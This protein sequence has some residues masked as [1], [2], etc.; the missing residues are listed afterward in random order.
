MD[1]HKLSTG[2]TLLNLA[3]AD[4]AMYGFLSG[5]YYFLVGDSAAGKTFLSVTCLAEAVVN[6]RFR[7]YRL[8]YDNIEDGCL[9][10]LDRLFSKAVAD[11]IE[12]PAKDDDGAP[13]YSST[14]EEFYYNVDDAVEEGSSFIYVL[15]SMDA[16]TSEPSEEKF[17]EHK[18]AS[19]KGKQV[20]GSYGD[21]KAKI[22]SERLRKVLKGIRDTG[23]IL[24]ILAQTRDNLGQGWDKKTRSGGWALKFYATAEIWMSIVSR[25]KRT[26]GGKEREIGVR[27]CLAVKKNR[28]T[29][30][31]TKVEVDIYPSYGIDDLGSVV[32]YLVEEG[33]WKISKQTITAEGIGLSGTRDRL[34]RQIEDQ[35]LVEN[36]RLQ[37][38]ACWRKVAEACALQRKNRYEC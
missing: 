2:S 15:D 5:K 33:V 38:G 11:R 26:V 20:A 13:K 23:S 16:L 4:D 27:V 35:G 29:G 24:I 34:L 14:V 21:G 8:I 19:R 3:L 22:N 6:K 9:L 17:D 18:E 32:D 1:D 36:V 31:L 28:I 25:L 12:P 7:N 37:A 10:D 30:K